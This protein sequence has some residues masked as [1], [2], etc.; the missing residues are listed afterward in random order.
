MEKLKES[1]ISDF[2]EDFEYLHSALCLIMQ[3]RA[4]KDSWYKW[5]AEWAIRKALG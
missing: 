1:R 4:F 3:S 5:M 2:I